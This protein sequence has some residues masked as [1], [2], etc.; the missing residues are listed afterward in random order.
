MDVISLS[1]GQSWAMKC[2]TSAAWTKAG[3]IAAACQ[4]MILVTLV[5][6]LGSTKMFLWWKSGWNKRGFEAILTASTSMMV[7]SV[8]WLMY[9][10]R[11]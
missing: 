11:R 4:S 6:S 5:G 8:F 9:K 10:I 7:S 2:G 1:F 3:S